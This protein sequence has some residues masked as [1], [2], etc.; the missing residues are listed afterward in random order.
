MEARTETPADQGRPDIK[1]EIR[2]WIDLHAPDDAARIADPAVVT[3]AKRQSRTAWSPGPERP[4]TLDEFQRRVAGTAIYPN[5]GQCLLYPLLGLAD[6]AGE[7][8]E[9]VLRTTRTAIPRPTH[10]LLYLL[11]RV[12]QVAGVFKKAYRDA[13]GELPADKV[14]EL[15]RLLDDADS[16]IRYLRGFLG[17]EH[18]R[19]RLPDTGS[20]G[21]D[22][23]AVAAE[24]RD[25]LWY[26]AQLATELRLSL[27]EQADRLLAKLADR[28]ARGVLRGSGDDR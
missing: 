26:G 28:K 12:G 14:E 2:T 5:Q 17:Y 23:D 11:V 22:V 21:L 24:H 18:L 13:D 16:Y 9:K 4:L 6:E 25:C 8:V 7:V 19:V 1:E 10:D 20:L 3:A 15:G 27:G